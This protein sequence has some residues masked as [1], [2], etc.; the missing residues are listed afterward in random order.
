[1]GGAWVVKRFGA[2]SGVLLC[3]NKAKHTFVRRPRTIRNERR[4]AG[5]VIEKMAGLSDEQV[6]AGLQARAQAKAIA[7]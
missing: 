6:V 2:I 7:I 5:R 4:K 3:I 1:M